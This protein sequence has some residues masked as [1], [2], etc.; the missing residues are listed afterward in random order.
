MLNTAFSIQSFGASNI[1]LVRD[2]NEDVWQILP[3][4]RTFILADGMGG[5]SAGEVA[6]QIAVTTLAELLTED[7]EVK[8]AFGVVNSTVY[9]KAQQNTD[10]NG[11]GTT[12]VCLMVRDGKAVCAH[13]GDSRIYRLR[14][15][16]L[17]P[18]TTDHTLVAEL[19]ADGVM[20]KEEAATFPYRHVL[21]RAIG[22]NPTQIA[23]VTETDV[24]MND[25]YLLCS[26]GL[27]NYVTDEQIADVLAS[28]T[29]KPESMAA[30]LIELANK[31]GGG[32]NITVIVIQIA[33]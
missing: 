20:K 11:M 18:L 28:Q 10:L 6:A 15:G 27:T 33:P 3:D 22:T 5:H 7:V 13:V 23:T 32:D 9:K 17:Q 25:I 30:R 2:H 19:T 1:G 12:L 26:D 4:N 29:R 24:F 21:T 16:L 14:A 8:K 31:N